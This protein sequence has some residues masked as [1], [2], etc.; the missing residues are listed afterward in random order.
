MEDFI[1]EQC[2]HFEEN[3]VRID[4]LEA[5]LMDFDQ[6]NE[7]FDKKFQTTTDER[8]IKWQ[9]SNDISNDMICKRCGHNILQL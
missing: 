4:Q 9:A 5:K 2:L 6:L 8:S 1:D 3:F 7:E